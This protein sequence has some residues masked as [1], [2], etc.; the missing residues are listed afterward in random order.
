MVETNDVAF[1]SLLLGQ[2]ILAA[3]RVVSYWFIAS[4]L[5]KVYCCPNKIG[6]ARCRGQPTVNDW[7]TRMLNAFLLPQT[8]AYLLDSSCSGTSHEIRLKLLPCYDLIQLLPYSAY[9]TH[10]LLK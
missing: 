8:E 9:F 3:L 2:C 10:F 4:S 5:S 1:R 6:Y 7:L